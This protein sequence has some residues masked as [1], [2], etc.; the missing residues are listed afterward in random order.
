MPATGTEPGD[1]I[2]LDLDMIEAD[3]QTR[4]RVALESARAHLEAE[5]D[6][7]LRLE[8]DGNDLVL[9]DANGVRYRATFAPDGRL[10][11]TDQ[12]SSDLL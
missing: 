1:F 2:D 8:N 4:I 5:I 7:S 9:S 10:I 11:V 12:R 3:R 6:A